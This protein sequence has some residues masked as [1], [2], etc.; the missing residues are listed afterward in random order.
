MFERK[1]GRLGAGPGEYRA[2]WQVGIEGDS[3]LIMDP[4]TGRLTFHSFRTNR[5]VGSTPMALLTRANSVARLGNGTFVGNVVIE[6][7]GEAGYPLHQFSGDGKKTTSFGSSLPSLR[8]DLKLATMRILSSS[9]SGGLWVAHIVAYEIE[10]YDNKATLKQV[11]RRDVDWFP[12]GTGRIVTPQPD[13]EPPQPKV[14]GVQEDAQGRLWILS[15]VADPK[16]RDAFSRE[17]LPPRRQGSPAY[18]GVESVNALYDSMIEIIDLRTKRLI[19]S[20]R[21]DEAVAGFAGPALAWSSIGEGGQSGIVRIRLWAL[22]LR[23]N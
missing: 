2:A 20:T 15:V 21:V 18:Y 5:E 8:P 3:L 17:R 12:P 6:T 4:G 1:I 16:W 14:V 11:L 13:G 23:D 7:P 10:L 9:P 22:E 19:S